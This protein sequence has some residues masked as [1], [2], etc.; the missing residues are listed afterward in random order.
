MTRSILREVLTLNELRDLGLADD[1]HVYN[2]LPS[3]RLDLS[4]YLRIR[5]LLILDFYW[6]QIS[7]GLLF[8]R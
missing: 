3:K 4:N 8:F 7:I 5:N 6:K 2:I 1:N